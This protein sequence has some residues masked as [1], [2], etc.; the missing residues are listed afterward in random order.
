MPNPWII[1]G[2][3][4]VFGASVW[5]AYAHGYDKGTFDENQ[6]WTIASEKL[7]TAAA[8]EYAKTLKRALAAEQDAATL[9]AQ[10]E[11]DNEAHK[12]NIDRAYA[13]GR[14]S[15]AAHGL[16]DPGAATGRGSCGGGSTDKPASGA[17]SGHGPAPA[18]RLLSDQAD[19]FLLS[20]SEEA[21]KLN[22]RLREAIEDDQA[23]RAQCLAH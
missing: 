3:V 9:R 8:G 12:S 5:Y 2:V 7:K 20:F 10:Q 18:G 6:T 14:A 16:L 22:L 19:Q 4:L 13:D 17:V 15:V 21:D 11:R 1:L 23:V